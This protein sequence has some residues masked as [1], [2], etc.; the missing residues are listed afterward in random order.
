VELALRQLTSRI[1]SITHKLEFDQFLSGEKRVVLEEELSS[2]L[3][4]RNNLIKV[5]ESFKDK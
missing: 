1:L 4:K 2:L 5:I 3:R